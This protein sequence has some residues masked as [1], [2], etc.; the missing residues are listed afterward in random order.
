MNLSIESTPREDA[1]NTGI[2]TVE[3]ILDQATGFWRSAVLRTAL[4]LRLA[5]HLAAGLE[6]PAAIAEAEGADTH[7]VE[8]LMD[9]LCGQGF[10]NKI[11]GRY[12]VTP[13]V[14]TVF[15]ILSRFAGFLFN[16]ETWMT[17]GR[18]TDVVRS[19]N[20]HAAA[21]DYW[22]LYAQ[23]TREIAQLQGMATAELV[24]IRPGAGTRILDIGCGSGGAGYAFAL[25]DPTATITGL[26][27]KEVLSVAADNA[28]ELGITDRVTL[29]A[30]NILRTSS[31]GQNEFGLAIVANVLQLLDPDENLNLLRRARTA[32]VPSGQILI[33]E[34]VAD[35]ERCLAEYPLLFAV[36]ML[37][38]TRAGTSYTFDEI[39][40][41]LQQAG[42]EHVQQH[43]LV[44]YTTAVTAISP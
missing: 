31:I 34:I 13:L 43:S 44:G 29:R 12:R 17:W 15:P 40:D 33:N 1:S 4:E 2:K 6:T 37:L 22:E 10:L 28:K 35:D 5:D 21:P 16:E 38:R 39:S 26:D 36:E 30:T 8:I 24:G 20:R 3:D 32:L 11:D 23:A 7:S 14:E 42:F 19:G 18:L 41:W 9:A 27:T 25:I